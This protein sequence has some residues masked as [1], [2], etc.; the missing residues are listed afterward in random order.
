MQNN[1]FDHAKQHFEQI[2]KTYKTLSF[3]RK[4]K[5]FVILYTNQ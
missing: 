4:Y 3:L 5:N 1:T 2:G